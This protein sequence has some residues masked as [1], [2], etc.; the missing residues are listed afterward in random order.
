[1]YMD[2]HNDIRDVLTCRQDCIP[3]SFLGHTN[4]MVG[5]L[6]RKWDLLPSRRIGSDGS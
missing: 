6:L 1:M 4:F 5:S 2:C 3:I